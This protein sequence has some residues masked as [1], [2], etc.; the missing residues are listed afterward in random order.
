MIELGGG[1]GNLGLDKNDIL[2]YGYAV[3]NP[4]ISY[5]LNKSGTYCSKLGNKSR[6]FALIM[7]D[8]WK[9]E[10]DYPW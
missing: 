2:P 4:R 7:H 10:D 1:S 6:C 3:S 5:T 8:G 9:I